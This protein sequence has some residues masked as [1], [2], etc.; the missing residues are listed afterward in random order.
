MI[1]KNKNNKQV[2]NITNEK[3]IEK[4]MNDSNWEVGSESDL[5]KP[6]NQTDQYKL[7]MKKNEIKAELSKLSEDIIQYSAGEQVPDIEKRK[8]EFIELHNEL[9]ILEGKEPREIKK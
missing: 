3:L 9:R 1:F 2:A 4:F 5:P 6:F 8:A 7:I